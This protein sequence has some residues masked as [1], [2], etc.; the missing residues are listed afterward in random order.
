LFGALFHCGYITGQKEDLW[1]WASK[2]LRIELSQPESNFNK[3]KNRKTEYAIFLNK[4]TKELNEYC[5]ND[6]EK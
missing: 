4:L 3:V 1:A 5:I 6:L 2:V